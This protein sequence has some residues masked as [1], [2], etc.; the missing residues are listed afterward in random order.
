MNTLQEQAVYAQALYSE[1]G[2]AVNTKNPN[3]LRGAID[4]DLLADYQANGTDRRRYSINGIP[5]ATHSVVFSK[6]EHREE[7]QVTDW[8]ALEDWLFTDDVELV[9]WFCNYV[10][11]HPR[12][13]AEWYLEKTG[14][15]PD[16]CELVAIDVPPAPKG[17]T[18]RI[19][20][21]AFAKATGLL[22]EQAVAR[23]LEGG[24]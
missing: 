16:G 22:P 21:Q 20:K 3:N 1:L 8:D 18:L 12:E 10:G 5:C 2:K 13:F 24:E 19:D 4:A 17:T 9:K 6:G 11:A 7:L 15:M 23:L 14:E